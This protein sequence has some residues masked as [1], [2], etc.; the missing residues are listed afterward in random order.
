MRNCPGGD[1]RKP[2]TAQPQ[3]L[4]LEL[5]QDRK[6]QSPP[7]QEQICKDL[8]ISFSG[9]FGCASVNQI[10]PFLPIL[11]VVLRLHGS[12]RDLTRAGVCCSLP[13]FTD[14][15]LRLREVVG[16]LLSPTW[17]LGSPASNSLPL[18]LLGSFVVSRVVCSCSTEDG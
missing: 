12:S 10:N 6:D 14:E 16:H 15:G 7:L 2:E 18:C 4:P 8:K 13:H 1:R 17:D 5:A 9:R 3:S 11:I